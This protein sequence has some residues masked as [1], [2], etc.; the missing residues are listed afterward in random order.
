[1]TPKPKQ[2]VAAMP[3]WKRRAVGGWI[4]TDGKWSIRGPIMS[5][6]MFWVY[7]GNERFTPTGKYDDSVSFK[8]VAQAKRFIEGKYENRV[9]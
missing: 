6:P 4:T 3:G 8:T 2:A 7:H 9:S 5:K 1:M